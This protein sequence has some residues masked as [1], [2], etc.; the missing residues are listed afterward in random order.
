MKPLLL[1]LLLLLCG[2]VTPQP[3]PVHVTFTP[4]TKA[5]YL[6]A[7]KE[8]IVINPRVTF[9][10]KKEHGRLVIPSA[11]GAHVFRDGWVDGEHD[12]DT[13]YKYLGYW[14]HL[15]WHLVEGYH[16]SEAYRLNVLTQSGQ[17][18]KLEELPV[19]AP[20]ISQFIVVSGSLDYIAPPAIQ[21]FRFKKGSW[22]EVWKAE[23]KTWE[24]EQI[25]W[26]SPTT[27][28]LKQKHWNKDFSRAWY[29]Y[30]RLTIH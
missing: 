7:V 16:Y 19:L 10:L 15:H 8:R 27:L 25:D 9:P 18:L 13:H 29:T 12:E 28:L 17:W 26:L 6:Q 21:L 1:R 5:A 3:V 20:G 22:Q 11:K 30:A 14:S 4:L 23:P 24:P 2:A